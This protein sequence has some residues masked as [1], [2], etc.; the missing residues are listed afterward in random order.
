M[1]KITIKNIDTLKRRLRNISTLDL[2][3]TM[4]KATALVHGQAKTLAPVNTGNLSSSIHM[5][6]IRK[7]KNVIGRVFTNV[8]YAPFVEFGTGIKGDGTYPYNV[9]GLNLSYRDTPWTFSPDGGETFYH[10][11][12]QVAQPFM[13]PALNDNKD[14]IQKMFGDAIKKRGR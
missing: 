1:A 11:S 13:Y 10:T 3:D 7:G 14:T 12:G 9:E 6:T 8:E 4:N 2:E 5:E